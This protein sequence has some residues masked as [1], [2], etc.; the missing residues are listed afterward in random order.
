MVVLNLA[1]HPGLVDLYRGASGADF[2]NRLVLHC[3]PD[4]MQHEPSC[5]LGNA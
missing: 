5:L 4:A 2:Q 3:E 1:A